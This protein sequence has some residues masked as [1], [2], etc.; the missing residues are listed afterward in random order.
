M[1]SFNNSLTTL[2]EIFTSTITITETTIVEYYKPIHPVI[3]VMLMA[4]HA[5]LVL[6]ICTG[7][8]FTILAVC[9]V[10]SLRTFS[11]RYIVSLA[12][13]DFFIGIMIPIYST[14][15][16]PPY[17]RLLDN[18]KYFCLVRIMFMYMFVG[19]SILCITA[20]AFDRFIFIKYPLRHPQIF[21]PLKVNVSIACMWLVAFVTGATPLYFNNWEVHKR[22]ESF[23]LL[24]M[25]Y[26]IYVLCPIFI[27]CCFV[28]IG[29]Y[30]SIVHE[31]I[32]QQRKQNQLTVVQHHHNHL[33]WWNHEEMKSVK[34][35]MLV[36][37][38][39]FLCWTP[40]FVTFILGYF[41]PINLTV[42][43]ACLILGY[44]NSGMNF[45]I[46]S[47]KNALFSRTFQTFIQTRKFRSASVIMMT[48]SLTPHVSKE[49]NVG[50]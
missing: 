15:L 46:Y 49:S 40:C 4:I 7:N 43:R 14:D 13:A 41:V 3:F 28:T 35:F 23:A 38:V 22:C 30:A 11:N 9:F 50:P 10:P 44:L 21:N 32:P 37:G 25:A 33:H 36:F 45:V 48:S 5:F 31:A 29:F 19:H 1:T 39:F 12:V 16:Y 42:Q 6:F 18:H 2:T 34:M 17:R 47:F 8:L 20:I 26:R 27:I 24:P